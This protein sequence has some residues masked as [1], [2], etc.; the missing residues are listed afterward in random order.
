LAARLIRSTS[1]GL[2]HREVEHQANVAEKLEISRE[3]ADAPPDQ[4]L[5]HALGDFLA[6]VAGS[7][8]IPVEPAYQMQ[9][10][11]L[12]CVKQTPHALGRQLAEKEGSLRE[13][14]VGTRDGVRRIV[15]PVV[16]RRPSSR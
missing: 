12:P 7:L 2:F 13:F 8:E 3:V 9:D 5:P 10:V 16:E 14:R 1:P 15:K 11:G 4:R 6:A